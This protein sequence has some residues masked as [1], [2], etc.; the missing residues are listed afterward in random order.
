MHFKLLT[1]SLQE[2]IKFHTAFR[3]EN[4]KVV[5]EN[6]VPIK[7]HPAADLAKRFAPFRDKQDDDKIDINE[8]NPFDTVIPDWKDKEYFTDGS[9]KG[10]GGNP[11]GSAASGKAPKDPT[12]GGSSTSSD[13]ASED[14]QEAEA[15]TG[16]GTKSSEGSSEG[17]SFEGESSE[18]TENTE[19][20]ED[21]IIYIDKTTGKEYVKIGNKY[22]PYS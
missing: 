5:D 3:D 2:D 8:Y 13:G 12:E 17:E 4:G 18:G 21:G 10:K 11:K 1:N 7:G 15:S 6:G 20:E 22:V 14:E 19:S 16:K 9:A